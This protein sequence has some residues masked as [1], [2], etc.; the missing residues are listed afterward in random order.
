MRG[1]FTMYFNLKKKSTA[2]RFLSAL[3]FIAVLVINIVV[4]TMPV[5]AYE[6]YDY[7]ARNK[8]YFVKIGD[9]VYF[10][11]FGKNALY[12]TRVWTSG[13]LKHFTREKGSFIATYDTKTKKVSKAFDAD[14]G[15]FCYM[16]K[17][18]YM[19]HKDT[20]YSVDKNG[21]KYKKLTDKGEIAGCFNNKYIAINEDDRG[22]VYKNNKKI[23]ELKDK[24]IEVV[25]GNYAI[26]S[27]IKFKDEYDTYLEIWCKDLSSS[28]QAVLLGTL[29]FKSIGAD[30]CEFH[31]LKRRKSCIYFSITVYVG[32]AGYL[33][34]G[35]VYKA[36]PKK[37]NSLK[38]VSNDLIQDYYLKNFD[39]NKK[40]KI[41]IFVQKNNERIVSEEALQK[42][43][44]SKERDN[45]DIGFYISD[46]EYI[47]GN[48]YAIIEK[49]KRN[50]E[51]DIG[52]REAYDILER[53]YVRIPVN[54]P[55]GIQILYKDV[56]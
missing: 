25:D 46:I 54:N 39:V 23:F 11:K 44:G 32:N 21:K 43:F 1:D 34:G 10:R 7:K 12:T 38:L 29:D 51:H 55:K 41:K 40:G 50:P 30:F 28:K 36:N 17:R 24:K 8:K 20:V 3:F 19:Q 31:H 56:Y 13:Y 53:Y 18:F 4:Q 2:T 37:E 5:K 6:P 42:L 9:K 35:Y 26:Y 14:G 49:D 22:V 16:N 52:W 48:Q 27:N 33:N 47:D 45:K 15:F